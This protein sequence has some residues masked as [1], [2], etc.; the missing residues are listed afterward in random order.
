MEAGVL[1]AALVRAGVWNGFL[2]GVPLQRASPYRAAAL[3]GR[4]SIRP[5]DPLCQPLTV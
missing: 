4:L 1:E 2:M 3:L 5:T